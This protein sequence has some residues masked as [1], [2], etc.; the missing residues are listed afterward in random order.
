LLRHLP[1]VG[2]LMLLPQLA[3]QLPLELDVPLLLAQH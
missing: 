1:K 3:W 2:Y